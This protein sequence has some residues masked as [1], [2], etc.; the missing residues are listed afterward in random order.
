MNWLHGIQTPG[1][2][3][4]G[5]NNT[6][7]KLIQIITSTSLISIPI[8]PTTRNRAC[9]CVVFGLM[10]MIILNRWRIIAACALILCAVSA[11]AQPI[12]DAVPVAD[13]KVPVDAAAAPASSPVASAA[14]THS[15]AT[16]TPVTPLTGCAKA[17]SCGECA[18]EWQCVWCP[19]RSTCVDGMFY[20]PY[21]TNNGN[22]SACDGW[23][24]RQCSSCA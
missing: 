15:N 5:G 1:L 9:L 8:T 7:H 14:P 24:W 18:G 11:F 20:G 19:E 10:R 2:G 16:N 3:W 13:V 22:T 4:Q 12:Q 21:N 23:Q 17:A 6:T